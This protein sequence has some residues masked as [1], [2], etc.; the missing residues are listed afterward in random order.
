MDIE[1]L[2]GVLLS[3]EQDREVDVILQRIVGALAEQPGVALARVWLKQPGDM[4]HR[5]NVREHCLDQK[6][7]LHLV[8]SMGRS[9]AEEGKEWSRTDGRFSR[10]P[11]NHRKIGMIAS[12]GDPILLTNMQTEKHWVADLDWIRREK[13]KYFAG[14]PLICRGEILGVMAVFS[15]EEVTEQDFSWLRIFAEHAAV[16]ISNARAFE[17]VEQLRARLEQE[18]AYLRNE[19]QAADEFGEIIGESAALHKVMDQIELVAPTDASVLIEGESGTGKELVARAIHERSSRSERPLVKVNCGAIPKDL[20]ESE[21]FGH[22]KGSF[23]GAVANRQGRFELADGGTLFLDEVGEIPLGLQSKLL[24][25]LQEGQFERVGEEKT[26]TVDVRIIAATNR[27]LEG[28]QEF[29]QDLYFRLSVFPIHVPPLRDR[30]EDVPLL[31][32]HFIKRACQRLNIRPVPITPKHIIQMQSYEWPGNIRELQNMIER[33]VISSRRSGVFRLALDA[34]SDRTEASQPA[35]K[36]E[37]ETQFLTQE[38]LDEFERENL[39]KVLKATNWRVSGEGGA[40][41]LM[42]VKPTTLYSRIKKMGLEKP[43]D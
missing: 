38:E 40:A 23:T 18:N 41:D 31:A 29:R 35:Q 27:R 13:I 32:E 42:G 5:C 12:T 39:K 34:P 3:I 7:C 10:F 26:S 14:H 43:R 19:I 16:A 6:E 15:R 2:Q 33:A 20:F 25:V 4:C 22:V 8:A 17:L 1:E 21:F 24:R 28:S 30:R 36:E 11:I 37:D 9:I